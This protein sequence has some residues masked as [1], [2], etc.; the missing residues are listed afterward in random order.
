MFE[1]SLDATDSIE[2]WGNPDAPSLSWFALTLGKFWMPLGGGRELFRY[3][4]EICAHWQAA[5]VHADYQV[6][7]FVR[8][9]VGA[10]GPALERLPPDLEQAADA[11]SDLSSAYRRA[12][13]RAA[14]RDAT[15]KAFGWLEERGP[16]TSWL[17]GYPKIY[18]LRIGQDI[19]IS[20]DNID[21]IVDGI[22]LWTEQLGRVSVPIADFREGVD[23]LVRSLLAQMDE[24]IE[25]IGSGALQLRCPVSIEALAQQREAFANEFASALRTPPQDIPWN[26]TL[27]ALRIVRS[28]LSK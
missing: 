20:Y 11:W 3:T 10:A 26:E 15:H 5:T 2:P 17:V 6:A 21:A 7:A 1:F 9:I 27:N 19:C 23:A 8:E 24:R 16:C 18:F 14:L 25:G 4:P 22:P 13:A 12:R 28:E